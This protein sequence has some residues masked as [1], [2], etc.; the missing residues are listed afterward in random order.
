MEEKE[1][2][3]NLNSLEQPLDNL[4]RDLTIIVVGDSGTGKTSF[5]NRYVLNKFVQ[6]NSQKGSFHFSYK[7]IEFDDV[8]Y[9][10]QIWDIGVDGRTPEVGGL[11]L[12]D[13]KGIILCCEVNN[14]KTR[15]NT[16]TWKKSIDKYIDTTTIPI[17]LI[18]NK[19]DLLGDED[20]NYN[21]NIYNL[22]LFCQENNIKK[23][24][25]TSALKGI[26]VEDSVNF[27]LKEIYL[28]FKLSDSVKGNKKI[29]L[30]GSSPS[31]KRKKLTKKSCS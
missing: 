14:D 23:F 16:I 9:R 26:G 21:Q 30:K 28:T 10:L 3:P 6:T 11:F 12:R 7:I 17:I 4:S 13:I 8:L 27:L 22:N 20:K 15:E 29:K 25:R 24:F 19:C 1:E 5:V 18:E 2:E 31:K